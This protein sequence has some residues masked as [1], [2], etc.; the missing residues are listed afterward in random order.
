MLWKRRSLRI[1]RSQIRSRFHSWID[2]L[3]V[4]PF[5]TA[6]TCSRYQI[7]F[8]WSVNFWLQLLY[9]EIENISMDEISIWRFFKFKKTEPVK[10]SLRTR[11]C[12]HCS[13][14]QQKCR[15][16]STTTNGWRHFV[17]Y[18]IRKKSRFWLFCM[19]SVKQTYHALLPKTDYRD[20]GRGHDR[21]L[22]Q[23]QTNWHYSCPLKGSIIWSKTLDYEF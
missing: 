15:L 8:K 11:L 17:S 13:L 4:N 19:W 7:A 10:I 20:K 3:K 1:I 14:C 18:P 2:H 21:R 22:L 16:K 23:I 6:V 9:D 12:I 5:V